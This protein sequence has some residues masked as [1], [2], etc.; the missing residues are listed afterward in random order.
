MRKL[1]LIGV[2]AL[3]LLGGGYV[4]LSQNDSTTSKTAAVQKSVAQ[5]PA[6]STAQPGKYLDFTPDIIAQTTGTKVLFF[7]A[8][9]CPQCRELDADIKSKGVPDGVS[10][11]KID[12]DSHQKERQKYG[13][14]I[15]TTLV[16]V[17]DQGNLVEKYVAYDE[18]NLEAVKRNLLD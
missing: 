8:P 1:I 3:I 14:T 4:L 12:Y 6:T 11:I 16:K 5:V 2:G 7:H 9:W 15:Q 10:I 13:I 17:D 18:P